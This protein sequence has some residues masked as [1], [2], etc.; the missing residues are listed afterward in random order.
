MFLRPSLEILQPAREE[1]K[2]DLSCWVLVCCYFLNLA[3]LLT[4]DQEFVGSMHPA[5]VVTKGPGVQK[6]MGPKPMVNSTAN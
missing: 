6:D 2:A 3:L 1:Q 4:Q 5:I